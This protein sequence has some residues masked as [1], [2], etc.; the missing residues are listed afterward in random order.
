MSKKAWDKDGVIEGLHVAVA[1]DVYM[2]KAVRR[3]VVD[4]WPTT[5]SFSYEWLHGLTETF[6]PLKGM[7]GRVSDAAGHNPETF[8]MV[9]VRWLELLDSVND[10]KIVWWCAGNVPKA[11]IGRKL[12]LTYPT[13]HNRY[14]AAIKAIIAELNEADSD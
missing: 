10:R 2:D 13:T 3:A 8:L 9:A 12:G 14:E 11:E 1:T 7:G 5:C 4:S 6:A